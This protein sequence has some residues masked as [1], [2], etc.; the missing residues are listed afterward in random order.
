MGAAHTPEVPYE[1]SF[2]DS[3]EN[4]MRIIRFLLADHLAQMPQQPLLERFDQF[5][6]AGRMVRARNRSRPS[7]P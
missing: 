4:R 2:P 7:P 3:D 5:S 6:R 1:L